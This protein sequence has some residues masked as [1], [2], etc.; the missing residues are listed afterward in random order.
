MLNSSPKILDQ[1][2]N[3]P[4]K[5]VGNAPVYM[6]D[7]ATVSDSFAVQ[8]NIVRVNGR[9]ATYLMILKHADASTLAVV[10]TTRAML[11]QIRKAA[12]QGME[13]NIDFDQSVFVRGA[14]ESVV[15]E[16]ILSSIL[17]RS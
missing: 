1:F 4:I 16:A 15:R 13:L 8:T 6:G 17:V 2:K 10:D 12:P 3:I 7:V 11:P 5:I 14:I 9:R